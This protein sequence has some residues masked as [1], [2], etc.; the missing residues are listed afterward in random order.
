MN[1]HAP[2]HSPVTDA[3]SQL[4]SARREFVRSQHPDRGGDPASFQ[5]G[6]AEFDR[7]LRALEDPVGP[8]RV[9]VVA[10]RPRGLSGWLGPLLAQLTG[11]VRRAPR[12]R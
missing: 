12:V 9:V 6:L 10:R 3:R 1:P 7:R 4:R 8:P 11:P 5:A 2:T